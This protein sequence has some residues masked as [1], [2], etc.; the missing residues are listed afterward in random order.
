M[1]CQTC[2]SAETHGAPCH[3]AGLQREPLGSCRRLLDTPCTA[4]ALAPC[5]T[6]AL[7]S[8]AGAA[9]PATHLRFLTRCTFRRFCAAPLP[10]TCSLLLLCSSAQLALSSPHASFLS[11]PFSLGW[12]PPA[13]LSR[14]QDCYQLGKATIR[15]SPFSSGA[16]RAPFTSCPLQGSPVLVGTAG[17]LPRSRGCLEAQLEVP[18]T[19]RLEWV[20]GRRQLGAGSAWLPNAAPS[21]LRTTSLWLLGVSHIS[22]S[23]PDCPKYAS[24]SSDQA[25]LSKSPLQ[26]P[27]APLCLLLCCFRGF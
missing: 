13:N 3:A 26:L 22:C 2:A 18:T 17:R 14:A 12:G 25:G 8:S 1:P 27:A 20:G 15:C 23:A 16:R 6:A 10:K 19:E 4:P 11:L 21:A 5:H 9:E 24:S 7:T